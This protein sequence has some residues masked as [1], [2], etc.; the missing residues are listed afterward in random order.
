MQPPAHLYS[1][2]TIFQWRHEFT[3]MHILKVL[4]QTYIHAGMHVAS[5]MWGR[6]SESLTDPQNHF[7]MIKTQYL[8]AVKFLLQHCFR[9]KAN[10]I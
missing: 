8:K 7:Q 6:I 5:E 10:L 1:A 4:Y 9:W 2:A 3:A